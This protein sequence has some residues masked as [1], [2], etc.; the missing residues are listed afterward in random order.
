MSLPLLLPQNRPHLS[1]ILDVTWSKSS[2]TGE[3]ATTYKVEWWSKLSEHEV[4]QVLQNTQRQADTNGTFVM[5]FN[6]ATSTVSHDVDGETFMT[7]PMNMTCK[8]P[9]GYWACQGITF[10]VRIWFQMDD[11]I[12][13]SKILVMFHL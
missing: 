4:K 9:A 13:R 2:D 11:N 3:N 6:G 12:C 7:V 10:C 5:G 1:G 8:P